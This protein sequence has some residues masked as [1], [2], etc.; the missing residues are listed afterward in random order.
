MITPFSVPLTV[1]NPLP[2]GRLGE[3]LTAG[4]PV[5][6]GQLRSTDALRLLD[7]Q[8]RVR[9]SQIEVSARWGDGSVK[10]LLL[11]FRAEV[12]A[13]GQAGYLL[14]ARS[15][16]A[17]PAAGLVLE[18][19]LD[20]LEVHGGPVSWRV[21][22]GLGPVLSLSRGGKHQHLYAHPSLTVDTLVVETAGPL[23]A[24]LCAEGCIPALGLRGRL[25]LHCYAGQS[26]ARLFFT[27][28]NPAAAQHPDNYWD[29]GD[30]GSALFA[31]FS[32]VLEHGLSGPLDFRAGGDRVHRGALEEG[33]LLY[34]DSSGGERWD[35][36]NH[37]DRNQQVH[38]RFQGYELRQ[39]GGPIAVGR[40][41]AG[42][43]A[44]GGEGGAVAVGVRH[45][46][47]NFPKALAADE[48]GL[49]LG[50]FPGEHAGQY[51]L[52]G[53]EQK[54][55]ELCLALADTSAQAEPV[56]SAF[57]QPLFAAAPSAWYLE[58]GVFGDQPPIDEE[59][60]A[61]CEV[62]QRAVIH[63]TGTNPRTFFSQREVIDEYGWRHFGCVM[64]DHE[65][66]DLGIPPGQSNFDGPISHYN[67]Q[68][69]YLFGALCQFAR[70]LDPL[71][72]QLAE[73]GIR[74]L[75]DIDVYHTQL[76]DPLYNG[77]MFWH[78]THD[79]N[80]YRSTHRTYPRDGRGRVRHPWGSGGMSVEH[81]YLRGLLTWYHLS[82]YRPALEAALECAA[83]GLNYYERFVVPY[84]A[85]F[86]LRGYGLALDAF[87][88]AY[89][90]TGEPRFGAACRRVIADAAFRRTARSAVDWT[91][92]MYMKAL[93]RF[94]DLKAEREEEDGEAGQARAELLAYA[95]FVL[96]AWQEDLGIQNL[97]FSDG[98]LVAY[99]HAPATHPGREPWFAK[100]A[101]L[102]QQG[103]AGVRP[104]Y[105][106]AKTHAILLENGHLYPCLVR[107][108]GEG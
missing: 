50:L 15:E 69:D 91:L 94:L 13:L 46:W 68:Y 19:A 65:D 83:F 17:P 38:N 88:A 79:V 107:R 51:E 62:A 3:P 31:D 44:L 104:T 39:G 20:Q 82:G 16:P 8:G 42:W 49:R 11:D 6:R 12:P 55:H 34:Q 37:M 87:V 56:L 45:C 29:L 80:A 14:A 89:Q 95:D 100:A 53:G 74:H 67:N 70:T 35:S 61:T 59:R 26:W 102:W 90:E 52:Q 27:L 48:R 105:H 99:L 4:L 36:P 41:A 92:P 72:F 30:P 73:E 7:G 63:P 24:T 22:R 86:P 1:H 108:R 40:R 75:A 5:P 28:H 64:A 33:L 84:G 103:M 23:R 57:A 98:L 21:G 97:R 18:A 66:D 9:P 77:A 96:G 10:W 58:S 43:L 47:Q 106:Y 101:E 54:T 76:D 60:F 2:W 78:T 85:E 81:L 71:W 93:G 32:L 25:R